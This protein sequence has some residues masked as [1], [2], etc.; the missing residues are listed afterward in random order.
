MRALGTAA[1]KI[2]YANM[3]PLSVKAHPPRGHIF[4]YCRHEG[5]KV[6]LKAKSK[7]ACDAVFY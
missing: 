6:V 7:M 4:A 2:W 1:F 3:L 5:V